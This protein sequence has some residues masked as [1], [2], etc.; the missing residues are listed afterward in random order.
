[1]YTAYQVEWY[2]NNW[3]Y[4]HKF[5]LHDM[6]HTMLYVREYSKSWNLECYLALAIQRMLY[7]IKIKLYDTEIF[8]ISQC[9]LYNKLLCY[10]A[11]P[12]LPDVNARGWPCLKF[13]VS[14][15]ITGIK[16]LG[17]GSDFPSLSSA[18]T[19]DCRGE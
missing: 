19:R 1:M 17:S 11:H 18:T 16:T 14:M 13:R 2:I 15:P 9:K 4:S 3:L 10:T 5:M 8:V 12:N 7:N 6:L